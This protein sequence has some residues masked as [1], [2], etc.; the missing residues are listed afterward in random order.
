[1][2]RRNGR[3]DLASEQA[4]KKMPSDRLHRCDNTSPFH[5]LG[6]KLQKSRNRARCYG[7]R[8]RVS[9]PSPFPLGSSACAPRRP[10]GIWRLRRLPR[11]LPASEGTARLSSY[12]VRST[13]QPCCP[14]LLLTSRF[15][16]GAAACVQRRVA[17]AP[18]KPLEPLRFNKRNEIKIAPR[19]LPH[20]HIPIKS[21]Q[22]P[23]LRSPVT[24][25]KLRWFCTPDSLD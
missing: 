10:G 23:A 19:T 5:A 22:A 7:T 18:R 17:L 6:H 16:T 11:R 24:V 12:H 21:R 3:A 9:N 15:S 2:S 8:T 25:R 13:K 20:P 4:S 14:K 1:M